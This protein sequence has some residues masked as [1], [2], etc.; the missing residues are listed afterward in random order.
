MFLKMKQ[1]IILYFLLIVYGMTACAPSASGEHQD[2]TSVVQAKQRDV[3]DTEM[4]QV[5]EIESNQIKTEGTLGNI[6]SGMNINTGSVNSITATEYFAT[7]INP[8]KKPIIICEHGLSGSRADYQ[9]I[10]QVFADNGYYVLTPDAYLHGDRTEGEALTVVEAAVATSGEIDTLLDYCKELPFVDINRIGLIGFSMGGMVCY[11]YIAHGSY[12]IDAACVVCTTPDW[13][14]LIGNAVAYSQYVHG[15][16]SMVLTPWGKAK[17]DS[18]IREHSPK[19]DLLSKSTGTDYLIIS[20]KDDTLMPFAG[21]VD[22]YT[23][24]KNQGEDVTMQL[25]E[26]HGHE[27]T[28]EDALDITQFMLQRLVID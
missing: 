2:M 5:S 3:E 12:Q 6:T 19:Q 13:E 4:T 1:Q 21:S 26:G 14:E 27:V 24:M 16:T 25:V 15:E 23:K 22:F 28:Q 9:T 7:S 10:A 8:D 11:D 18:F 20:G 17:V